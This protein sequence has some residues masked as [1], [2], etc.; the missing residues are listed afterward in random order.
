VVEHLHDTARVAA[1]GKIGGALHEQNNLVGSNNLLD[2][3][4]KIGV[5]LNRGGLDLRL[6]LY[7]GNEDT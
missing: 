4:L 6:E 1:L 5:F 3:V 2:L 7:G